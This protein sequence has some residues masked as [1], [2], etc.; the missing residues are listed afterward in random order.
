MT[1]VPL[2]KM[3]NVRDYVP[4]HRGTIL[5]I[6]GS[7][8]ACVVDD[9]GKYSMED[10]VPI[11]ASLVGFLNKDEDL[12]LLM[13]FQLRVRAG[14]RHLEFTVYPDEELVDA[15]ILDDRMF[16]INSKM[17]TLLSLR[18]NTDQFV[19]TKSEFDRFQKM[20]SV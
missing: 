7:P 4:T 9:A 19:K 18:L 3:T 11:R 6:R 12:G 15:L 8:V 16:V 1:G 13:G 14:D 5:H 10:G 20:C 2:D 17:D